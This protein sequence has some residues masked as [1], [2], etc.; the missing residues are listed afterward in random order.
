MIMGGDGQ[1][2]LTG[3]WFGKPVH[4]VV[5]DG[6]CDLTLFGVLAKILR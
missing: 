5:A 6:G 4:R 3:R 2:V 1:I